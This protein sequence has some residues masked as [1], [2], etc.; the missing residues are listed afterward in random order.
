MQTIIKILKNRLIFLTRHRLR[1]STCEL[2]HTVNAH[3]R[4]SPSA[5]AG[6]YRTYLYRRFRAS[7]VKQNGFKRFSRTD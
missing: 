4:L 1:I 6:T 2:R 7:L 3:Y 5:T